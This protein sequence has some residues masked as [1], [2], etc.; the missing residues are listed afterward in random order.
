MNIGDSLHISAVKLPKGVEPAITDRDFTICT[1]VPS[2][3]SVLEAEDAAAEA[4]AAADEVPAT[5][6]TPGDEAE[7][8]PA[9][10]QD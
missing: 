2:S 6:A 8:H 10:T 3:G 9:Q 4:E 5:D 1:I 7:D